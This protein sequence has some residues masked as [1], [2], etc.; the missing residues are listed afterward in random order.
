[1]KDIQIVPVQ[2]TQIIP[3][4]LCKTQAAGLILYQRILVLLL[5]SSGAAYRE[6][7]GASM[8]N[9]LQGINTPSD[10]ILTSLGTLSC[11]QVRDMLSVEDNI[12]LKNLYVQTQNGSLYVTVELND[13]TSYKGQLTCN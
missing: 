1:M 4:V 7:Q 13:G 6:L 9:L 2:S 12:N 10:D 8:L 3:S 5:S 11:A